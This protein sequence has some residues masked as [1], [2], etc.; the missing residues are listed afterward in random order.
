[1]PTVAA[2]QVF[3]PTRLDGRPACHRPSLRPD[4][5]DADLPHLFQRFRR[6]GNVSGIRGTGIGL[7]SARH[8]VVQHGGTIAVESQE[9]I[10]STITIRLP[11]AVP[12]AGAA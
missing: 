2:S 7:A 6:G 12:E 9:G 8:I 3:W 10:G 4:G 11:L 5:G 1:M